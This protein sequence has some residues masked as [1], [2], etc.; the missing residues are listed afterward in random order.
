MRYQEITKDES[1]LESIGHRD[2]DG[3]NVADV[4][5][6]VLT[7]S[8]CTLFGNKGRKITESEVLEILKTVSTTSNTTVWEIEDDN[9]KISDELR[10][11]IKI[12]SKA[13]DVVKN[14]EQFLEKVKSMS[15]KRVDE[16]TAKSVDEQ[17]T[18]TTATES[19]VSVEYVTKSHVEETFISKS[20]HDEAISKSEKMF[21]EKFKELEEVINLV[22]KEAGLIKKSV[23]SL[24]Q[25]LSESNLTPVRKN[26]EKEYD[27]TNGVYNCITGKYESKTE[28]K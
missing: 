19:I 10:C 17:T 24:K 21:N 8:I 25:G 9:G 22:A 12:P 28:G 11:R 20:M 18:D 16:E 23:S 26:I 13:M 4:A 3:A 6:A 7:V 27:N 1:F 2:Y 14:I 5:E 15:F